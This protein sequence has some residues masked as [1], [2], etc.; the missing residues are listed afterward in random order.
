MIRK[1]ELDVVRLNKQQC[2][3]LSDILLQA[4]VLLKKED[5]EMEEKKEKKSKER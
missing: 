3:E 1:N 5:Q 2:K 4:S